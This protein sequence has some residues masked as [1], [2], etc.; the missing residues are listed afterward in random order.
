MTLAAKLVAARAELRKK[1][2]RRYELRIARQAME[3][4][5]VVKIDELKKQISIRLEDKF[6]AAIREAE[7]EQQE[8]R[9][10]LELLEVEDT[11][12]RLRFPEGTKY[13]EYNRPL[14]ST[15]P[16]QKIGKCA[17]LEVATHDSLYSKGQSA[18]EPGT[19]ILRLLKKDGTP[20]SR[21]EKTG[22]FNNWVREG[23]PWTGRFEPVLKDT[24]EIEL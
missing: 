3:A 5:E 15:R 7:R 24:G 8:A 20:S 6:G 22:W 18:P 9:K 19:V 10:A 4:Q 13:E 1:D 23:Q 16:S 21:W 17:L 12:L 11:R 14:F 2:V